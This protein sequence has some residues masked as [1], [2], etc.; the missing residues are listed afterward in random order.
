MTSANGRVARRW[1]DAIE[2]A[3]RLRAGAGILAPFAAALRGTGQDVRYAA[4]ALARRPSYVA[5]A[6]LAFG[7]GI[8]ANTAIFSVV[9]GVL[10]HPLPYEDPE[11]LVVIWSDGARR[12]LGRAGTPPADYLEIR[13][14]TTTLSGIAGL[15]NNSLGFSERDEPLVPLTHAVTPNFFDVLGV[16][17]AY[18]RTFAP[19]EDAADRVVIVSHEIWLQALEGDPQAV[20]RSV[21]LD[22]Q[23]YVVIGVMPADFYITHQLPVQPG[24][25]IPTTFV[26]QTGNRQSRAML[27]YGRLAEGETVASVTEELEV[28]ALARE[29]QFPATHTGWGVSVVPIRDN[30][31]GAYAPVLGFMLLAVALVLLLACANVANLGLGQAVQRSSEVALR[32]ALGAGRTRIVRQLVA[33]GVLLG[34]GG[35]VVGILVGALALPWLLRMIP[36]VGGGSSSV[37]GAAAVP[38]LDDVSID[39]T[40]LLYAIGAALVTGML[41]GLAPTRMVRPGALESALRAGGR[42][43]AGARSTVMRHGLVV[44]E[45]AI[46]VILVV[47]ALTTLQSVREL[48][49]IHLGYDADRV[50]TVRNSIR[51]GMDREVWRTHFEEARAAITEIPGVQTASGVNFVPPEFPNS[52]IGFHLADEIPDPET[53]QRVVFRLVLPGYFETMGIPIVDGRALDQTDEADGA[54]TVVVNRAFQERFL[55]ATSSLGETLVPDTTG[56][57]FPMPGLGGVSREIVGVVGNVRPAGQDPAPMPIVYLPFLQHPIGIMNLVAR[58][59][60]EPTAL[61]AEVQRA[62]WQLG[63]KMNIYNVEALDDRV[64]NLSWQP[65]FVLLLL[66]M[67][68]V[69]AAALGAAGVYAVIAHAVAQRRRELGVRAAL[70]ATRTRLLTSVLRSAITPTAFGLA[71]G[72]LGSY[73]TSRWLSSLLFA[74]NGVDPLVLGAVAI[75]TLVVACVASLG[76]A[77]KASAADPVETLRN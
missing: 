69:L 50:L 25:W 64:G 52:T 32:C 77:W 5:A 47:A 11:D 33:E 67:F 21:V 23:E 31:V 70:G 26:G 19:G 27:M 36:G 18:G 55:P 37:G 9:N 30:A 40:V 4:R 51:V 57:A 75:G 39:T 63:R 68:A 6:V 42:N 49:A 28:Q 10:L 44:A 20:G 60:G 17:A 61:S 72:I 13:D 12:G 74:A 53:A 71:I 29:E 62:V 41:A 66:G 3:C 54:P 8:G 58:T 22:D 56:M 48:S 43:L 45:A 16:D 7:L 24:L 34:L 1:L 73:A 2:D 59:E 65:R 76:P 38:F 14:S 15:S 35:A 46:A